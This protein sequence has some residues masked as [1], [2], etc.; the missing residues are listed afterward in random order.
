M[1]IF[2]FIFLILSASEGTSLLLPEARLLAGGAWLRLLCRRGAPA[3]AESGVAC[4]VPREDVPCRGEFPADEAE[5]HQPCPHREFG[6]F[7]LRFFGACGLEAFRRFGKREAE[8]D[9]ALEFACVEA[10]PA[11]CRGVREL[12]EAKFD[13]AFREGRVEVQAIM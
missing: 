12:E 10:A 2:V 8:L 6:V 5:A 3:E 13:G 4:K 1:Y 9:V 7:P 11:L